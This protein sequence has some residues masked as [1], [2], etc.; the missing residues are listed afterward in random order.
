MI[1][2]TSVRHQGTQGFCELQLIKY[3]YENLCID[4]DNYT[5][6]SMFVSTKA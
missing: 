1:E 5:Y 6:E 3:P 4:D 2:I